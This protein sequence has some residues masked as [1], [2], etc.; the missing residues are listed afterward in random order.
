MGFGEKLKQLRQQ[1]GIS[2][3]VVKEKLGYASQSYVADAESNKFIPGEDKLRIWAEALAVSWEEMQDILLEARL[4][5]LGVTDPAFTM[6][7]KEVPRMTIEEK[8]SLIRAYE[9]II[10]ARSDKRGKE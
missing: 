9:G 6:M 3:R 10:R 8:R 7:F 4:E 2:R 1:K 5:E